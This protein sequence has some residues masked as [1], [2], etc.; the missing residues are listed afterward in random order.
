LGQRFVQLEGRA[1]HGEVIVAPTAAT[2]ACTG[3]SG[4]NCA[5]SDTV[6]VN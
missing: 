4:P 2:A 1:R 3:S 5:L 6:M